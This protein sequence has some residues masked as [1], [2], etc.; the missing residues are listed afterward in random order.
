MDPICF[1]CGDA[2]PGDLPSACEGCGAT[3]TLAVNPQTSMAEVD[4][5]ARSNGYR[6]GMHYDGS[7]ISSSIHSTT[8]FPRGEVVPTPLVNL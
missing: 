6:L 1:Y 2:A 8:F 4:A 5:A 7:E 3:L